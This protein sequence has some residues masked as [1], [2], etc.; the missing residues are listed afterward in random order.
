MAK[1]KTKKQKYSF[2]IALIK[3][4]KNVG[5]TFGIPAILYILN[6]VNQLVPPKYAEFATLLASGGIYLI[7]NYIENK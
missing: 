2:K 7:K 4:L 1:T 6:N 5:L 3:M